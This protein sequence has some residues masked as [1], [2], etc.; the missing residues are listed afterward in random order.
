[1][2]ENTSRKLL[3][4]VAK[5]DLLH[6][7]NFAGKEF[8]HRPVFLGINQA[9]LLYPSWR[10]F[11]IRCQSSCGTTILRFQSFFVRAAIIPLFPV[12]PSPLP[13][14]R[15][16]LDMRVSAD[17]LSSSKFQ[18]AVLHGKRTLTEVI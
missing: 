16:T 11:V 7:H 17:I 12:S 9:S 2:G 6:S 13:D 15:D 8:L 4:L 10:A 18:V 3:T 1:M 5:I 14:D